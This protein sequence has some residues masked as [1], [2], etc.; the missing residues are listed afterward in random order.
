MRKLSNPH[1]KLD[2]RNH[3]EATLLDHLKGLGWDVLALQV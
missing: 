1:I 2:E 3:V